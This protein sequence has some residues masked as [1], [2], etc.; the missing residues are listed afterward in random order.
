MKHLFTS[1]LPLLRS[2][3]SSSPFARK[4]GVARDRLGRHVVVGVGAVE[5]GLPPLALGEGGVQGEA[6]ALQTQRGVTR[7]HAILRLV[8]G[9]QGR[10]GRSLSACVGELGAGKAHVAKLR[11]SREKPV[12]VGLRDGDAWRDA[13]GQ[14]RGTGHVVQNLRRTRAVPRAEPAGHLAGQRG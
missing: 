1:I 11:A 8:A 3:L 5:E 10:G 4:G 2:I 7:R 9:A 12:G 13:E 14:R 6:R